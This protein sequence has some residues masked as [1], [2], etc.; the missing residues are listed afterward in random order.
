MVQN[1]LQNVFCTL[2][3]FLKKFEVSWQNAWQAKILDFKP[4]ALS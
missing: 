3:Y 1:T 2:E 4:G